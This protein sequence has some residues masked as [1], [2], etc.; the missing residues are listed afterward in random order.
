MIRK[1]HIGVPLARGGG[2]GG[3]KR[4]EGG[5]ERKDTWKKKLIEGATITLNGA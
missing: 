5:E 4:S 1:H 3:G 2:G